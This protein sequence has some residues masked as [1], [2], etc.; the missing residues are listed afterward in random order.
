MVSGATASTGDGSEMTDY[1]PCGLSPITDRERFKSLN[2]EEFHKW[3]SGDLL[4]R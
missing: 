3:W 1:L 2:L 4:Q